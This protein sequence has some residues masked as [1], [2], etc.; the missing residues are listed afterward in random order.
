MLYVFQKQIKIRKLETEL[1][2]NN[3]IFC[4]FIRFPAILLVKTIDSYLH[5]FCAWGILGSDFQ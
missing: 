5:E 1:I 4:L 2:E 3:L